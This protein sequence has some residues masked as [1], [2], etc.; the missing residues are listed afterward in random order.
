MRAVTLNSQCGELSILV[1][2]T[3]L[4]RLIGLMGRRQLSALTG[5]WLKPCGS[6]HTMWMRF[7]IDVLYL[8]AANKVLK[9]KENL[10][11]FRLDFAPR[12]TVSVIELPAFSVAELGFRV[13]D[14]IEA[15]H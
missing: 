8:D 14:T 10:K 2:D 3:W 6:I 7:S 4:T 11:P 12:G 15:K 9:I 13:G 1:A 5:L